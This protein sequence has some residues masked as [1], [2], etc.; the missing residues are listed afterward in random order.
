[1]ANKRILKKQIKYACGDLAGECILAM[2][3]VEGIDVK[4][5]QDIVI[6]IATLQTSSLQRVT[7]SYDKT[8]V[9][10]D[11]QHDYEVAKTKYFKQAYNTL[12]ADFDEKVQDIV[13]S[14]NA[15]LPQAQ[16]EANKAS[17]K[18]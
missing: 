12:R 1:M 17:L 6:E 14:M 8:K 16:K 4:G 9:D 18:A 7:F 2:N 15:L 10:F 13:K 3:F 5:M 11:S